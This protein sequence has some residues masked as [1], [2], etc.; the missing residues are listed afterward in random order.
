M[1]QQ[2]LPEPKHSVHT[3][4]CLWKLHVSVFLRCNVTELGVSFT[5]EM[6]LWTVEIQTQ[7]LQFSSAERYTSISSWRICYQLTLYTVGRYVCALPPLSVPSSLSCNSVSV[8]TLLVPHH[9]LKTIRGN[10]THKIVDTEM[11]SLIC[12]MRLSQSPYVNLIWIH[13]MSFV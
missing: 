10:P 4:G 6:M 8:S 11:I 5:A 2:L 9:L 12:C 13:N 7:V 1:N 3:L